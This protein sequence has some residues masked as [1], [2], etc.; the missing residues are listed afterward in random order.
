MSKKYVSLQVEKMRMQRLFI[1]M[2]AL[3]MTTGSLWG[4]DDEVIVTRQ[5]TMA[6]SNSLPEKTITVEMKRLVFNKNADPGL[7]AAIT[8][9]TDTIASEDYQN[10]TFVLLLEPK[11]GGEIAIAA[12]NDDIVTRG[13]MNADIYYGTLEHRRYH[14]VLLTSK[15]NGPLLEST[16]KRQGKVKFVQEFEF[17]DFKTPIYPTNVIG[18]WSQDKGLQLQTVSINE[19]P[20][21]GAPGG[22]STD[23]D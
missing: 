6:Q 15:D 10:R 11:E 5:L 20:G 1:A 14:F 18:R 8:Q 22:G 17:V 7:V 16:F 9:V 3:V 12:R 4:K 19:E 13:R 21:R 23:K 2:I